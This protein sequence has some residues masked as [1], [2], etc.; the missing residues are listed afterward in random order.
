M[1]LEDD[2]NET[3]VIDHQHQHG[4][5]RVQGHLQAFYICYWDFQF[6]RPGKKNIEAYW[7]Q[8]SEGRHQY[9]SW[10]F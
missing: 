4:I 10:R 9:Y 5:T 3:I 8:Y 7:D 6:T 1:N 2:E